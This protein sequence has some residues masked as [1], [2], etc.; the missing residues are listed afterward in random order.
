M[1]LHVRNT[2]ELPYIL[3]PLLDPD[4][5][6]QNIWGWEPDIQVYAELLMGLGYF[7]VWYENRTGKQAGPFC[8]CSNQSK[9]YIWKWTFLKSAYAC[10][11]DCHQG[12]KMDYGEET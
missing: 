5:L 9:R 10:P 3:I 2:E 8:L 1:L 4:Q 6:K 7:L 12:K 11:L